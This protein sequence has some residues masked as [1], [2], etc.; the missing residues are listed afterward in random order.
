MKKQASYGHWSSPISAEWLT[1]SQKKFGNI[2][3]DGTSV[4]WDEMRPSDGG[5]SVVVER[6]SDGTVVERMPDGKSCRS[7]VHEY[8]GASFT[9]S[10]GN[11]YYVNDKDQRIYLEN[12]PLSE[13]GTRCADLQVVQDYL[14]A[15]GEKG[16]ENFLFSLHLPTKMMQQIAS[17]HDFYASP[18]ISKDGSRIAYLTW[19]HPNMPWDGTTLWVA[20]FKEGLLEN[21]QAV[22]GS[23]GESIFQPAWSEEGALYFV[24][25]KT[26]WWNLY[27]DGEPICPMEAEFGLPQWQFGMSTYALTAPETLL[28]TYTQ[29]SIW[30]LATLP[31]LQP[32]NLPWTFYTQIR[33]A[34]HSAAFIAASATNDRSVV[35]LD[36]KTGKTTLLAHNPV[37]HLD[38]ETVSLPELISSPT[39]AIYYPPKNKEWEAPA[40][41]L[42]PLLVMVHGGPTAQ[43][44]PI[45]DLK[46]QF[47]TSRGF[48]VLDINHR[49]S[50]GYGRPYRDALKKSWGL[51][52]D[53]EAAAEALIAQKKV[54]PKR[55]A[56]RGGSAGGYTTLAALTFGK[57]FTVGASYYGVSDLAA[58]ALETHKF[59]SHYL[60]TLIGIYPEE[61]AAY[62][63]RSPLF[64]IDQLKCPIIFFQGADDLV[65]PPNQAELM[66]TALKKKGIKTDLVI[67]PEEQHGFRKA[68]NIKDSLLRELKFYLDVWG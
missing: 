61:K 28:A 51:L 34:D 40:G 63:A 60:D 5:R 38:P 50:T 58:L 37:P 25:D 44:L 16:K 24:S 15:V 39:H 31:P 43:T 10:Q 18:T 35:S 2:A 42:P 17:G 55:V 6:K 36:L 32:L 22:A 19:D 13:S 12:D 52:D 41:E 3:C 47:W 27:K 21:P 62:E 4:Y 46:I 53:C 14:V 67:Y 26:G 64:H 56:I 1:R 11:V 30:K 49:G 57:T 68:E 66:Y 29:N 33:V 8:G 45:F 54:D 48:A 20:D 59:E 65:V 7:R 9:A 23:F